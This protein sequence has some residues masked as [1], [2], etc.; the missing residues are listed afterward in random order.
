MFDEFRKFA[1]RGNV[2]DLAVGVVVGASF[3]SIV[4]SLVKDII[5]P[6]LGWLTGGLDFSNLYFPLKGGHPATLAEAQKLGAITINYGVFLNTILQFVIVA[7]VLFLLLHQIN[8]LKAQG[9]AEAAPAVPPE[10]ILLLREIRDSL[11]G[12]K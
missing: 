8:R 12:Q 6:P 1:M 4:N 11:K 7:F 10:E 5:T 3:T 2:V 9:A